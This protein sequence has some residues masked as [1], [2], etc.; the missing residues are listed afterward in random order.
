MSFDEDPD[1]EKGDLVWLVSRFDERIRRLGK[2]Y[3]RVIDFRGFDGPKD[4]I[5]LR[6]VNGVV[7]PGPDAPYGWKGDGPLSVSS[8]DVAKL[9]ALEVLAVQSIDRAD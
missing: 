9:S 3:F 7:E 8:V 4:V 6:P 2:I 5:L 1:I